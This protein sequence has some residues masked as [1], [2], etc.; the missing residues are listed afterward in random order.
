MAHTHATADTWVCALGWSQTQPN[1]ISYSSTLQLL[2]IAQPQLYRGGKWFPTQ[3]TFPDILEKQTI[4]VQKQTFYTW[5][6]KSVGRNKLFSQ[7]PEANIFGHFFCPSSPKL[8]LN[9]LSLNPLQK[10]LKYQEPR[11]LLSPYVNL[12]LIQVEWSILHSFHHMLC[13]E[14]TYYLTSPCW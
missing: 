4:F 14:I 2:M 13:R 1:L 9:G 12:C 7:T 10:E 5:F 8:I 11:A 6:Y 3:Q